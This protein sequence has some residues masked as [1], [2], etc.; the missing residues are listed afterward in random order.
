M[1]PYLLS[2]ERRSATRQAHRLLRSPGTTPAG[3]GG[4][5][6][7]GAQRRGGAQART[8]QTLVAGAVKIIY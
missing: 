7:T 8:A 4:A 5:A 1:E 6:G 2:S 3:G